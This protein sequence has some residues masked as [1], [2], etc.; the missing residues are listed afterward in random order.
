MPDAGAIARDV[1]ATR[2]PV[3]DLKAAFIYLMWGSLLIFRGFLDLKLR[4]THP[5]QNF[6]IV[7]VCLPVFLGLVGCLLG[8]FVL[9]GMSL[10]G[11]ADYQQITDAHIEQRVRDRFG[12]EVGRLSSLG[13]S[14]AYT[15]GE[16]MSL[17]RILLIFPAII[18]LIMRIKGEVLVLRQGKLLLAVP[19]FSSSDGRVFAHSTA[20]GTTF[21]T[22]F[23]NGRVL[24]TKNYNS[25]YDSCETPEL[26][27]HA[28]VGTIA[29]AWQTHLEWLNRLDAG[30]NPSMRDR[31]YEAYANMER[32]EDAF[33]KRQR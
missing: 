9:F 22:A 12:V 3:S 18:Y 5:S 14:Y 31:R 6:F 10:L 11:G 7:G 20:L 21:H 15:S 23:R 17:L 28:T 8:L 33:K 29:E 1:G 24:V 26:V 27:L 30:A 2:K 4:P 25:G 16:A 32:R 19:V 13:F